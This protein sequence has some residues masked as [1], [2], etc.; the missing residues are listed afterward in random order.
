MTHGNV[1]ARTQTPPFLDLLRP[2]P[3]GNILA[4]LRPGSVDSHLRAI[5]S[6]ARAIMGDSSIVAHAM[7]GL[8]IGEVNTLAL[9]EPVLLRDFGIAL[10]PSAGGATVMD[11][12][13]LAARDDMEEVRPEFFMFATGVP[14]TD[15]AERTWGVAAVGART[16]R[17]TGRGIRIAILDTGFQLSHPDFQG[18]VVVARNFVSGGDATDVDDVRGHGSHCVGTAAGPAAKGNRPR[19]GVATE[20][21]IYIGKVL[22]DRGQGQEFEILAGMEWA[23]EQRCHVISMSLGRAVRPGERHSVAYERV[24]RSALDA[25]LLIMAA[26][27]NASSRQFGFIAPVQEPANSPSIMAVA[28]VDANGAVADFSCGAINDGGDVDIA[29]PGVGIFSSYPTPET[30]K[31]LSGTSMAC[32]HAAGTAALWAESDASLR[33]QALFDALAANALPLGGA[34]RDVGAGLVQAPA[35]DSDLVS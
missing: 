14:E 7:T 5:E 29:A 11:A 8:E 9:E 24:G 1:E 32:P 20:A 17:F 3:T 28:A 35:G 10:I 31:T 13:T 12:Q 19:Y 21:E 34:S 6:G 27:G 26:A 18:R 4:T 23:I 33:G 16:S 30:Y 15:T 22:N 2:K 25:G